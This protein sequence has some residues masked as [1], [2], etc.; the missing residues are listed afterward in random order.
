MEGTRFSN[1][2]CVSLGFHCWWE[3]WGWGGFE[4]LQFQQLTG[5]HQVY[6][7]LSSDMPCLGSLPGTPLPVPEPNWLSVTQ[8]EEL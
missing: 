6:K 1:G 7:H 2:N 5:S 4:Q 8:L 3:P